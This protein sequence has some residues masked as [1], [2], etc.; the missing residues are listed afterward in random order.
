MDVKGVKTKNKRT[1]KQRRY[2]SYNQRMAHT[3]DEA[4][5]TDASIPLEVRNRLHSLFGEIEGEF[6][7]VYIS[8]IER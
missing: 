4:I 7:A 5:D 3:S 2:L 6:E 1:I 8:R